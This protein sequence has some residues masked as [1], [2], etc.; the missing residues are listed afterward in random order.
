MKSR[1]LIGMIAMIF[2][3]SCKSGNITVNNKSE[4]ASE[5]NSNEELTTNDISDNTIDHEE[6]ITNETSDSTVENEEAVT[7]ETKESIEASDTVETSRELNTKGYELYQRG[8]YLGALEYFKAAFE[9]DNDYIHAHYNYA[10]TLGVLMKLDYPEWYSFRNDVH[11]HLKRAVELNPDY[12]EKIKR[13]SD[14]DIIRKDF[15]YFELLG[16]GTESDEDI[17]H[18]LLSLDWYINGPGVV[19]PIGGAGFNEDGTFS[20]SFLDLEMFLKGEYPLDTDVFTGRYEVK[21]GII[22]FKLDEKML[23]RRGYEDFSVRDVY[24]EKMEFTGTLDESGTLYIEIFD[25][26]IHNWMDEFSA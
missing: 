3:V 23:K 24:E 16:Y 19:T 11:K 22:Y 2:L 20:L 26:P 9:D 21:D 1:I 25:Y 7:E 13:D 15:E 5:M 4:N 10:C 14:L 18:L 17:E 12:I 8:N 6:I